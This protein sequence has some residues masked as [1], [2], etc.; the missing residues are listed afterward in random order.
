M[1]LEITLF[2]NLTFRMRLWGITFII[3]ITLMD[4]Q[5]LLRIM[6][7]QGQF[8][9]QLHYQA[10]MSSDTGILS[11]YIIALLFQ[12][13]CVGLTITIHQLLSQ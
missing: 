4:F 3:K 7:T 5:P 10:D 2:D 1:N 13:L 11:M 8:Q 9:A 12:T 6:L